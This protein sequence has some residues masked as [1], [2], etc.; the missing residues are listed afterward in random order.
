[1]EVGDRGNLV[2]DIPTAVLP[3]VPKLYTENGRNII[4]D[5]PTAVLP[6]VPK[7]YTENGRNIIADI[8]IQQSYLMY[9]NCIL[10]TVG[11]L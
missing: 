8:P 9:L 3:Y 10:K 1:M 7:L 5:I 6:Y 4:A 2:V 11:I